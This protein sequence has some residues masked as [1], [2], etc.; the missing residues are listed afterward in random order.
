MAL[1]FENPKEYITELIGTAILVFIGCL[2]ATGT[3]V[4]LTQRVG[5]IFRQRPVIVGGQYS[6]A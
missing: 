2:F 3:R 5:R 4:Q 1:S 6:G